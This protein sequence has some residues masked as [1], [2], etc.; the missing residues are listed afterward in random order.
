MSGP[1]ASAAPSGGPQMSPGLLFGYLFLGGL[2]IMFFLM[3]FG[4]GIDSFG[5]AKRRYPEVVLGL[6][7]VIFVAGAVAMGARK[8]EAH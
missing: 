7:T 4:M 8:K 6:L 2:G 3:F 5:A 1:T